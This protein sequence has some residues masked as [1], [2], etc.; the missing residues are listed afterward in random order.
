MNDKIWLFIISWKS[1]KLTYITLHYK[2]LSKTSSCH[3]KLLTW[4]LLNFPMLYMRNVSLL[5][6]GYWKRYHSIE[7]IGSAITWQVMFLV[8]PGHTYTLLMLSGANRG[9]TETSFIASICLEN[10]NNE[11]KSMKNKTMRNH[12]HHCTSIVTS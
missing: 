9:L 12:H 3:C 5:R 8:L 4:R 7:G 11:L 10:A 1:V 6:S 2:L